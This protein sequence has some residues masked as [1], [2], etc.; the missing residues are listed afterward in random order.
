MQAIILAGGKGTRMGELTRNTPKTLLHVDGKPILGTI[1]ENLPDEISEIIIVCPEQYREMILK[2][3]SIYARG[4]KVITAMQSE[5]V[6][7]SYGSIL[8]AKD[9]IK[10]GTFLV[11]N[12]DDFIDKESLT[13]ATK[14]PFAMVFARQ[15]PPLAKYLSF[16]IGHD[17]NVDSC[18]IAGQTDTSVLLYTG[19]M[20]IDERLWSLEPVLSKIDEYGLPQT[21]LPIVTQAKAVTARHWRGFNTK[22]DLE[23]A[24]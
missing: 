17:G 12:S 6:H 1:I 23:K 15:K 18:D 7:G 8:S 24:N 13:E 20:C 5:S 2:A 16:Q 21:V 14:S 4:R 11:L 3:A 19:A 22:E 10:P 9:L